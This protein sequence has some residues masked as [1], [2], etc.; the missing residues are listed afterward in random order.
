MSQVAV[1]LKQ[2]TGVTQR[3]IS[4]TPEGMR[5][6]SASRRA[7]C[8]GCSMSASMPPEMRFRVVSLPATVSMRKKL[9]NSASLRLKPSTSALTRMVQRSCSS[10][11]PLRCSAISFAYIHTCIAASFASSC[12]VPN[13]GSSKPMRRLD[14]SK[15]L[16]RSSIGTPRNSAMTCNGSSAASVGT[17]SISPLCAILS[18]MS[19]VTARMRGSRKEITNG[20]NPLLTSRRNLACSGGSMFSIIRR[21]MLRVSSSKSST[22][23]LPR[24]EENRAGSFDAVTMSSYL[25]NA[26]KSRKYLPFWR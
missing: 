24:A 17:K 5:D 11:W 4:S 16:C 23:A 13:S 7:R 25:V 6:G 8:S 2:F 26:Q 12:E 20:V 1:R 9:S 21:M 18:R 22:W 3:S 14:Q 19:V 10:R 15:S